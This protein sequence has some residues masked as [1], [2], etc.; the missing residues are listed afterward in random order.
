MSISFSPPASSALGVL[1]ER[2]GALTPA[3]YIATDVDVSTVAADTIAGQVDDYARR[4]FTVVSQLMLDTNAKITRQ[5]EIYDSAVK[6]AEGRDD[7]RTMKDAVGEDF[8]LEALQE[9]RRL[10]DEVALARD[11]YDQL[12][13]LFWREVRNQFPKDKNDERQLQL[14]IYSD[15]S[16][17]W[18][19]PVAKTC[20]RCGQVHGS[21]RDLSSICG[22][23]VVMGMGSVR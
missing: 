3:N 4:L 1:L 7:I 17:A 15:W 6:A 16:V 14:S 13:R 12:W 5:R 19:E 23:G 10:E 18:T 21:G 22:E 9:Y 2:L 11:D 20:P 8:S